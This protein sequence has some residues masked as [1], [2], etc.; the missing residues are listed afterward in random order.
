M[1][2]HTLHP[3]FLKRAQNQQTYIVN[4][5]HKKTGGQGT[6]APLQ[7]HCSGRGQAPAAPEPAL[8]GSGAGGQVAA[9]SMVARQIRI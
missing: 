3:S 4:W 6:A 7:S 9:D 5:L 8:S 2:N 1:I